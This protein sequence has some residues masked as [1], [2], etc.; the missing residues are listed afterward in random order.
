MACAGG[1]W[2]VDDGRIVQQSRAP[3][4]RSMCVTYISINT[5]LASTYICINSRA[6]QPLV[7]PKVERATDA[8]VGSSRFDRRCRARRAHDGGPAGRPG[9]CVAARRAARRSAPGA[10]GACHQ[11][12]DARN[13][14][15]PGHRRRGAGARHHAAGRR[16]LRD[17]AAQPRRGRHRAHRDRRRSALRAA[18]RGER[19]AQRERAAAPPRACAVRCARRSHT[20]RDALRPDLAGRGRR[21]RLRRLAHRGRGERRG[22]C[23]AQ[24]VAAG[25]RRREQLRAAG[26]GHRDGGRHE[27]G[28][29]GH[30]QLRGRPAP[31]REGQ[32]VDPVLDPVREGAGHLH[33]ARRRALR[34]V[35]DAVLPAARTARGLSGRPL[36]AHAACRVGHGRG[37]VSHHLALALDDAGA[38]GRPLPAGAHLADRR[39]GA[40]LSTHGR[41]R[42]QHGHRGRAQPG[43][44]AG[45]GHAGPCG[46]GPDRH[47]RRGAS[48]GGRGELRGQREELSQDARGH[49]GHGH[50][51]PPPAADGARAFECAGARLAGRGAFGARWPVRGAGRVAHASHREGGVRALCGHP[52]A[53]ATRR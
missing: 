20:L 21:G 4:G 8:R 24:P 27:P 18:G 25:G 47:L 30:G 12:E 34:G 43:V 16:A 35:H 19:Q 2:L 36:R 39:C 33:R 9:H 11:R 37:A 32:P 13:P 52:P 5:H 15:Q 53:R 40:P 1:P 41:A 31:A 7:L 17:V 49:R 22:L 42:A 6:W 23:R 3:V 51:R 28:P 26:R 14:G 50:R 46:R 45:A 29:H 48:P 38:R 44:E 10:A